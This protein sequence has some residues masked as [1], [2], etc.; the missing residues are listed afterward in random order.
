MTAAPPAGTRPILSVVVTIVEGGEALR[1]FLGALRAQADGPPLEVIVPFDASAGSVAG[2]SRE[3]PEYTFLDLGAVPT[4]RAPET[5]S[6]QHELYD[7]RR[8]AGLA[9]ARGDLVAI[10]EDRGIPR[11]DWSRTA[12]RTARPSSLRRD[13]RR[14]RAGGRQPPVLGVLGLRL[15]PVRPPVHGAAPPA[16]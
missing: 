9:A 6:G 4:T 14:D 13:R 3:F 10:L 12:V 2:L 8:A 15:F 1:R 11:P 16:G 7:R 5:A